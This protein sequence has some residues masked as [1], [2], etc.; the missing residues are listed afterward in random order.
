[1]LRLAKWVASFK[2]CLKAYFYKTFFKIINLLL[3]WLP[4]ILYCIYLTCFYCILDFYHFYLWVRGFA[5]ILIVCSISC[6]LISVLAMCTVFIWPKRH[7]V[8]ILKPLCFEKSY[9]NKVYHYRIK[10]QNA[11][12]RVQRWLHQD[13][14]FAKLTC[15]NTIIILPIH[16]LLMN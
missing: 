10:P 9:A 15:H 16:F 13:T 3:I 6:F 1:M 5:F 4:S 8:T 12:P 11:H 2:V 7:F 14:C